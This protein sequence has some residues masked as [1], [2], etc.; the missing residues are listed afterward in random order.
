MLP[1]VLSQ[2]RCPLRF[3]KLLWPDTDFY[4]K[5]REVV[6]S[7]RDS[8]ETYVHAGN[9]LGKDYVAGFIALSFFIRPQMYFPESYV[10]EVRGRAGRFPH[11]RRVVTTSVKDDHL[12]VLWAEIGRFVT[13]SRFSLRAEEGGPLVLL[14]H[15][16]RLAYERDA[17]NPVNYLVGMVSESGEGLSGHHAAYTLMIGDEASGIDDKAYAAGQGWVKRFL[18]IGNP[19]STTNFFFR[20]IKGGDLLATQ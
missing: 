13:E 2:I 14:N 19:N 8:A 15:E 4:D 20:G 18:F 3:H 17:K 1:E 16:I 7:V 12:R 9:Q 5:Q 10:R 11:S 6:L